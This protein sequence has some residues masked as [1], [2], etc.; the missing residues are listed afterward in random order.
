MRS[1]Y[2]TRKRRL[3]KEKWTKDWNGEKQPIA[4]VKLVANKKVIA[5]FDNWVDAEKAWEEAVKENRIT[6]EYVDKNGFSTLHLE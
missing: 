1:Y 5:T 3:D 4:H 2:L 6:K